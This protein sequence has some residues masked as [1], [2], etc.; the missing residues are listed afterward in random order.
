[1]DAHATACTQ[2][3]SACKVSFNSRCTCTQWGLKYS[4][5]RFEKLGIRV[6]SNKQQLGKVY[7]VL[8]SLACYKTKYFPHATKVICK[9]HTPSRNLFYQ[10]LTRDP[11]GHTCT[12]VHCTMCHLFDGS[13]RAAIF[14]YLSAKNTNLVEDIEILLPLN[15]VQRVQRRSRKHWD[16]ASCQ[17][18]LNSIQRF[19]RS[20]KCLNQSKAKAA[21]LFFFRS[22]RKT[23]TL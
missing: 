16:H 4:F 23:Q 7:H 20:K 19:Q 1:M 6:A 11:K 17:V 18:S 13:V 22:A 3:N 10:V 21:I 5:V 8:W 15:S 12:W 14:I 2:I 9:I